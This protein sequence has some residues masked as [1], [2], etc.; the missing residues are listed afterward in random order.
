MAVCLESQNIVRRE[1][2]GLAVFPKHRDGQFIHVPFQSRDVW[3]IRRGKRNT[4]QVIRDVKIEIRITN[5][6]CRG[7]T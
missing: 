1:M 6:F 2:Q 3:L 5:S 4:K 7:L